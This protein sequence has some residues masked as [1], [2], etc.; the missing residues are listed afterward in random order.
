MLNETTLV[1]QVSIG[2]CVSISLEYVRNNPPPLLLLELVPSD[3]DP[4]VRM[5][6]VYVVTGALRTTGEDP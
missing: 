1:G 3:V 6:G 5:Y 4:C 2:P